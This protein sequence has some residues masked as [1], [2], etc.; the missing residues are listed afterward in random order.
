MKTKFIVYILTLISLLCFSN[1]ALAFNVPDHVDSNGNFSYIKDTASVLNN[2]ELSSLNSK[3]KQI[4]KN[5]KN[6]IGVLIIPSLEGEDIVS[7]SQQVFDKWKIGK[8]GLDN[9]V[10]L[11]IATNDRKM[12]IATGSGVGGDL[13]DIKAKHIQDE[14]IGPKL[15]NKDYF[16]AISSGIDAISSTLENHSKEVVAKPK[17][18]SS[19]NSGCSTTA[20]GA[21]DGIV[22]VLII[23]CALGLLCIYSI[24][25]FFSIRRTMRL[26]EKEYIKTMNDIEEEYQKRQLLLRKKIDDENEKIHKN[27]VAEVA[28]VKEP[29]FQNKA[30]KH[31]SSVDVVLKKIPEKPIPKP[32]TI[33]IIVQKQKTVVRHV[34]PVVPAVSTTSIDVALAAEQARQYENDRLKASRERE[35]EQE[36]RR[37]RERLSRLEEEKRKKELEDEEF[38][39]RTTLVNQVF[40]DDS[41]SSSSSSS[42][43]SGSFGGGDSSGGGSSS[44]W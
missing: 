23:L 18:T 22:S 1:I 2:T 9:G 25:S 20:V 39:S 37:E 40:S 10:L 32:Q 11:L 26:I 33:K 8:A 35:A 44:D 21:D 13:P 5:T 24:Y 4:S 29:M 17:M 42:D 7:V 36:R 34:A 12:R 31:Y 27:W 16:G 28:A 19:N 41:S 6:E 30:E 3:L 14:V 38:Y 15:K 43:D